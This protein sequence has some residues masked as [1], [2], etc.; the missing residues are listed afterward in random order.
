MQ[1]DTLMNGVGRRSE[2]KLTE[3]KSIMKRI[4]KIAVAAGA[5][6]T[7]GL[8]AAAVSAQPVGYGMGPGMMGGYGQGYGPGWGGGHMGGYGPGYGMGPGTR[9]GYGP[10][11]GMG[12]G[13][14]HMGGYGPGY[15]MGPQ[16]MY[17]GY[18]GN[19][20]ESLGALK[21]QLGITAKQEGAW[22]AFAKNAKQQSASRQAWFAKMQQLRS[23]GSAPEFLAQR[24]EFMKQR[25]AELEA[26]AAALKNLYAALT[27]EQQQL[28]DRSFGGYGPAYCL[29]AF[30]GP[31]GR[32]R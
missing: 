2:T 9:G 11:Y 32:V 4:T 20:D 24:T 18:R 10:G 21:A 6:L 14:G 7:L 23:A 25:Q 16:A 27:P 15:G 8:G 17:G 3:R 12:W 19:A 13:G 28:A 30:N 29:Q 31:G 1:R 26:N 5:A 22:Q